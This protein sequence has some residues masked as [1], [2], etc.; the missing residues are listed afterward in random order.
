MSL[1]EP[2]F[3]NRAKIGSVF[4]GNRYRTLCLQCSRNTNTVY[5]EETELK[6][7]VLQKE[8]T[9]LGLSQAKLSRLSDL[10]A[11]TVCGIERERMKPWPG[12]RA[13][14]ETA[15]REAG[16]TGAGDLFEVIADE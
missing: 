5:L 15:M 1:F 4:A 9:K 3:D 7:I 11:A 12:Q 6:M 10:N 8:R 13:K 16:W 2:D 14:I